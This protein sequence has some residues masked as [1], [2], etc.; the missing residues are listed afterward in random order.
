MK[1][2]TAGLSRLPRAAKA[3]IHE[4]ETGLA[5]RD[6]RIKELIKR[7]DALEEQY[8]LALARQYAPKSEK[9]KDRMFNEAE[10][11]ADAGPVDDDDVPMLPDTGL[12]E[13]DK[14]E[15]RKRGRKPLPA[16]HRP[17]SVGNFTSTLLGK[18]RPTLTTAH[19]GKGVGLQH[20][21]A[22]YACRH[23]ERHGVRTPIV[24]ALMPAQPLPGS[25]ASPSM[26]PAVTAGKYVDG[27]PLYRMEDVLARSNIAVSRGTLANWI[28]R[29]AELH[30]TRI[31]D[32]LKQVL[33]SQ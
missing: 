7:L 30:H 2:L 3:C 12:P 4:L 13:L 16:D 20:A 11:A 27:T 22:K 31:C 18:L 26:I 33:R 17:N 32:A 14:P 24:V 6:A 9:R 29:P 28:I 15:T 23:C 19:G 10:Q 21:R 8:R 1:H 25:H 5:E